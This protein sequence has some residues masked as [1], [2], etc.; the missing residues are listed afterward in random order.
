MILSH[1]T[2][3]QSSESRKSNKKQNETML[4]PSIHLRAYQ[5][6]KQ[7]GDFKTAIV[8]LNY[9]LI[10]EPTFLQYKDTLAMLY[11]QTNQFSQSYALVKL[12]QES[13]RKSNLL[14]EI[15]AVSANALNQT[16]EATDAYQALYANT[17]NI[18]HGYALLQLQQQL[19]RVNEAQVTCANLLSDTTINNANISQVNEKTKQEVKVPL[20]AV[21]LNINGLLAYENKAYIE[22]IESFKKALELAPDYEVAAQNLKTITSIKESMEKIKTE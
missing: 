13:G 17:K 14:T 22:S 6:C 9:H 1:V 3:S 20:K 15:L 5:N 4:T 8:A 21:L 18:H 16:V 11:V 19:K 7:I 10:Q 2:F 12:L